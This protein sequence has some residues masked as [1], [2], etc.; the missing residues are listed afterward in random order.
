MRF[1]NGTDKPQLNDYNYNNSFT[2]F[3]YISKK[4]ILEKNN[5]I[6]MWKNLTHI[7]TVFFILITTS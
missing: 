6:L 4:Y 5:C 3:D 7:T 1:L 2:F